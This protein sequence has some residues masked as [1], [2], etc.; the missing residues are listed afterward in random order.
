MNL[1]S[2]GEPQKQSP[3]TEADVRAIRA[4][5]GSK[6]QREIGKQFGVCQTTVSRIVNGVRWIMVT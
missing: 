5:A 3:L 4:L 1:G 2:R 6:S